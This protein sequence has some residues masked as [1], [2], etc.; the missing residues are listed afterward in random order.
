MCRAGTGQVLNGRTSQ[1]NKSRFQ[2]NHHL[3][4][5]HFLTWSRI[6]MFAFSFDENPCRA[7]ELMESVKKKTFL[8][9]DAG[10]NT[11]SCARQELAMQYFISY[12][13]V[14]TC[15]E[16]SQESNNTFISFIVK[17]S[18][19]VERINTLE[20]FEFSFKY[21]SLLLFSFFIQTYG[22]RSPLHPLRTLGCHLK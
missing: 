10:Q 20:H 2:N 19:K 17:H 15:I 22:K 4:I 16:Y 11:K 18:G 1:K 9:K 3:I 12:F 6:R 5:S 7:P 14:F 21:V 13:V 8:S